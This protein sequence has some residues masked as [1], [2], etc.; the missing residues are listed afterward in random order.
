MPISKGVKLS[1][2]QSPKN[3]I[4]RENMKDK[5]YASLVG[6]LMYTQVCTR[7]DLAFTISVLGRFQSNP[8]EAHWNTRKRV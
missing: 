4:E 8:G 1:K 3:E 2:E 7:P 6:S 5:P